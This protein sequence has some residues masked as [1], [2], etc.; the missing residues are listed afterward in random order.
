MFHVSFVYGEESGI[1]FKPHTCA[2]SALTL[3]YILR[4]E[5]SFWK[6]VNRKDD[7]LGVKQ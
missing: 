7:K 5:N 1:I 6:A 3:S 4:Q 2:A